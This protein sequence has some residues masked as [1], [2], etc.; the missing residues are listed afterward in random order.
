MWSR[1]GGKWDQDLEAPEVPKPALQRSSTE[2][3]VRLDSHPR[4]LS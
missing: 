1:T 2:V 3:G 4:F